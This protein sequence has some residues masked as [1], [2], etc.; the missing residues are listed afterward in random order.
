M[1]LPQGHIFTRYLGASVVALG[2]DMAC[3]LGLL[4]VGLMAVLASALAYAVGV[5]VHWWLSSRAVFT[6]HVAAPGRARLRQKALFVGSALAGLVVTMAVVGGLGLLGLDARAAK[7]V[8]I[9]AS[10]GATWLL[11]QRFVFA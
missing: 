1:R 3:Y 10:F 8:A 2:A 7:L 6:G 5:I 9:V 4:H 11:R